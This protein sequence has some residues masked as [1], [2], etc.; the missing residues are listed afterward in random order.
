[1]ILQLNSYFYWLIISHIIV[2]RGFIYRFAMHLLQKDHDQVVVVYWFTG[3]VFQLMQ[4]GLN[5]FSSFCGLE[6]HLSLKKE[7]FYIFSRLRSQA[8]SHELCCCTEFGCNASQLCSSS[9]SN[10]LLCYVK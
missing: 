8:I 7:T 5:F 9:T 6:K 3:V 10:V 2:L 4:R 1:M